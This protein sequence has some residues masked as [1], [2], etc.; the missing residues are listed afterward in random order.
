[1]ETITKQITETAKVQLRTNAINGQD[2]LI[3]K[4]GNC[5]SHQPFTAAFMHN[6]D[7][8][9]VEGALLRH[10]SGKSIGWTNRRFE[11]GYS[12]FD[13]SYAA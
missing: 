5:E 3:V 7:M 6:P 9:F 10:Y 8:D 13:V 4:V 11:N 12:L 1:M 2:Y